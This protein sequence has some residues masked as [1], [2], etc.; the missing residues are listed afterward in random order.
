MPDGRTGFL[1]DRDA[2]YRLPQRA[3]AFP[4]RFTRA[5]L[6]L[7][8]RRP[9]LPSGAEYRRKEQY[10]SEAAQSMTIR[11]GASVRPAQLGATDAD[12]GV[13]PRDQEKRGKLPAPTTLRALKLVLP[14]A[15]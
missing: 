8:G 12:R 9:Q 14:L 11:S 7:Q 5:A 1:A 3:K 10:L 2:D 15:A 13:G 4:A 6:P